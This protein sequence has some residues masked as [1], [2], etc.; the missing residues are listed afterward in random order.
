MTVIEIRPTAAAA[1]QRQRWGHYFTLVYGVLGIVIG[2]GLQNS[3]LTATT[4]YSN[5]QAGI[6]AEYPQN[7]LLDSDGDYVFRVRDMAQLGF[8]TTIQI[9]VLPVTLN[10]T[11]RNLLD[12]LI[13]NRSQTLSEFSVLSRASITI[14]D[15][16]PATQMRYTFAFSE[17]DPFLESQPTI[18]QGVDI[19]TLQGGQ[20]LVITFLADQATYARDFPY[21]EQF[22]RALDV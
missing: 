11:A 16:Q 14:Q 17:E 21:F 6:R 5:P 9:S 22:I 20:A 12:T 4:L 1:T 3:A 8:K 19:L 15:D 7:W 18:V 2:L 13:L 10:T